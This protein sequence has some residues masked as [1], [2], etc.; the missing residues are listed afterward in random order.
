[1]KNSVLTF[2][3][4]LITIT[5]F[6][7]AGGL[8]LTFNPGTG[9]NNA[10]YTSAVQTDGKI[11]IAGNFTS[12]NGSPV[13]RIARLNSDGSLDETFVTGTGADALINSASIQTDGK[14]I[15]AGD[16][17]SYNG[18][19]RNRIARIN[20]DGSLDETFNPGSGSISELLTTAIQ[21]DGKI[22]VGGR[23][24]YFGGLEQNR[25]TRLNPDGSVDEGFNTGTGA[26]G[27][28]YLLAP[29]IGGKILLVGDF[30][31]FN[32]T[33]K[34]RIAR[35]N[36]DGSLDESFNPESGANSWINTFVVN[37]DG[38]IIIGGD[39]TAY[40]E[41]PANRIAR[42]NPDG[43]LDESFNIGTGFNKM[44]IT[45]SIQSNGKIIVGGD[46]TSI[47]GTPINRIARLNTDGSLDG[48]FDVGTGASSFVW[49]SA[50]QPD[51]KIIIGGFFGL[52]G[53]T[54][55]NRIARILGITEV[56]E[57]SESISES[58]ANIY[59]NPTTALVNIQTNEKI[60]TIQIFNSIGELVQQENTSNFSVADLPNGIY[61]IH[62][63]TSERVITQRLVKE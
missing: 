58:T 15:I 48:T 44:V 17:S 4:S 61:F 40:N 24:S 54:I 38:K 49:T 19:V 51:G 62:L 27:D 31:L 60:E 25:I 20:S 18:V 42:L 12:Y 56:S 10:V 23:F 41:I 57:I 29:Q 26:S 37:S 43:S 21:P 36:L 22:L 16:F 6:S 3:F 46:F 52:Y 50:I 55:I 9:A 5:S 13:N 11:I 1:M 35:L 2:L 59:P 63:K 32:G 28:V 14:I 8:D 53:G 39:F 33:S 30:E 45:S 7:Q 34:K 47:N